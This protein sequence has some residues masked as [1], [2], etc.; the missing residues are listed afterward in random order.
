[1]A[2]PQ[3]IRGGTPAL[4]LQVEFLCPAYAS[5]RLPSKSPPRNN[6]ANTSTI[7]FHN[8]STQQLYSVKTTHLSRMLKQE[9]HSI[10]QALLVT[11]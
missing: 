10:C 5:S 4:M 11:W 9:I 8:V 6:A 2:R 3:K 1:M 7:F